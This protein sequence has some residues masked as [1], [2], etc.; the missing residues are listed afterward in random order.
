MQTAALARGI[1]PDQLRRFILAPKTGT[2]AIRV[3]VI[4]P[5]PAELTKSQVAKLSGTPVVSHEVVS[6]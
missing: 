5:T 3:D 2:G 4:K 1:N 6:W